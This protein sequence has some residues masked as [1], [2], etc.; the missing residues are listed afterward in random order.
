MLF[1]S[2]EFFNGLLEPQRISPEKR[3]CA[4]CIRAFADHTKPDSICHRCLVS[5]NKEF[6]DPGTAERGYTEPIDT[7]V[8]ILGREMMMDYL[9]VASVIAAN[10]AEACGDKEA[11]KRHN[12]YLQKYDELLRR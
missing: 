10:Q 1:D 11:V 8:D 6:F 7:L 9:F 5:D 3:V 4:R 2:S 12:I